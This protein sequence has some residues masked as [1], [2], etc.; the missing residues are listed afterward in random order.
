MPRH[1][2]G[3][4]LEDLHTVSLPAKLVF[5][6]ESEERFSLIISR[7]NICYKKRHAVDGPPEYISANNKQYDTGFP[8]PGVNYR[9]FYLII[10]NNTVFY[11]FALLNFKALQKSKQPA[12]LTLPF[13]PTPT[14][15]KRCI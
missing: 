5:S 9:L 13:H 6:S 14:L 2:T 8:V 10:L 4:P 7:T 3:Q 15:A 1:Y 11:Y 12:G